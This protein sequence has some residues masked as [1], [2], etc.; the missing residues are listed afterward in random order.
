MIYKDTAVLSKEEREELEL[1]NK[2]IYDAWKKRTEF[3]KQKMQEK[4]KFKI[5]DKI[6]NRKTGELL[7]TV[8]RIYRFRPEDADILED[9]EFSVDY[10]Y[11]QLQY[12]YD[13]N[14]YSNTSYRPE[15]VYCKEEE[16]QGKWEYV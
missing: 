14:M 15:I 3:F 11:K 10:E 8:T 1:L 4:S 9:T 6:Y 13:Y 5:E 12:E 16:L 7:G 2:N